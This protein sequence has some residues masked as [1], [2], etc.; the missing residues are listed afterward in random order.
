M[1]ASTRQWSQ[2][3]ICRV[4]FSFVLFAPLPESPN[5]AAG[6]H[7][8]EAEGNVTTCCT[9]LTASGHLEFITRLNSERGI[10]TL[11]ISIEPVLWERQQPGH[12]GRTV[13]QFLRI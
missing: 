6:C 11:N 12:A 1:H 4:I 8:I 13:F 10:K 9:I 7:V 2:V 3:H 5:E